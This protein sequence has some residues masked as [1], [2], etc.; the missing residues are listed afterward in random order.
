MLAYACA[1]RA[2]I[3]QARQWIR[4]IYDLMEKYFWLKEKGLYASETTFDWKLKDYRGQN[5]NMHVCEAMLTA[6]EVTNDKL[7]LERAKT[8]AEVMTT[9]VQKN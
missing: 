4:E 7:Y 3:E 2:G 1:L 5:D 9:I 6:Y 8:L